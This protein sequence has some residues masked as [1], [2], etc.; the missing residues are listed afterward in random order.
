MPRDGALVTRLGS[1]GGSP[2]VPGG[3]AARAADLPSMPR[4]RRSV[5]DGRTATLREVVRLSATSPGSGFN[6]F[7]PSFLPT[8][9]ILL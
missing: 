9:R 3:R 4:T 2:S 8:H 6:H 5:A 7:S 1:G